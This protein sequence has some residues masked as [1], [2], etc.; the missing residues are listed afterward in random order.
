LNKKKRAWLILAGVVILLAGI[1]W[2]GW[3]WLLARTGPAVRLLPELV[4]NRV[5]THGGTYMKLSDMPV[6]LQEALVDTEDNSFWHNL[7]VDP[8]GIARSV[9][10]DVTS[11]TYQEGGSTITQQLARNLLLTPDKTIKR[12][13]KE[14]LLA[15][16][17]TH[18]Y[19]KNDIL[20]MY[21]NEVYLGH[22]AYGAGKAASVYFNV[23][24]RA[25]SPA[26]CTMLAGIPQ[27]PSLYDP[28]E[29]LNAARARQRIVLDSM[30][31]ERDYTAEQAGEV[32]AQ[33]LNLAK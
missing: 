30:V 1:A 33:P 31:Q 10:A 9:L 4:H 16:V 21:L 24:L 11:G 3:L 25:L 20:E 8:S 2:G 18:T 12:K 13:I 7:G 15:L 5:E 27:G 32:F 26:Q 29:D 23:P 14:A 17:I 28:L 22:G 6:A 19:S